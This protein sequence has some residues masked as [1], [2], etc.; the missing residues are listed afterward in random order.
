[1]L[2]ASA[3]EVNACLIRV[4]VEI[5]KQRRQAGYSTYTSSMAVIKQT[6]NLEGF[7]GFYRGYSTTVM[8][9]IPFSL[10]QFPIWER[11]KVAWKKQQMK[12][13]EAWQSAVC[14]SVAGGFSAGKL[15]IHIEMLA[16]FYKWAQHLIGSTFGTTIAAKNIEN[17]NK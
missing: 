1:M 6:W 17:L 13:V 4:P 9:E 7:K 2:A 16:R 5:V 14:G 12:D 3:G 10:I 11:L 15:F 8:R